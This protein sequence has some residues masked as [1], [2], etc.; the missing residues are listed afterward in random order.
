MIDIFLAKI[1]QSFTNF[2]TKGHKRTL[3]AKKNIATSFA[4]KGISIAI[5]LALVPLTI[6]YINPTQYGIWLT[7]SSIVAW[8]S[9]FDIGF[10]H[11]LRNRFAE[12]KAIGNFEKARIYISTTYA[13]LALIFTAVWLLFFVVN[14]F[15]DWSKILNA[16]PEM[17][18]ELSTLALIVFSFFCLQIVLKTINTVIIAD[19][20]PAKAAFFDMLGQLISL[21]IIYLLTKYTNGSLIY[22]GIYLGFAPIFVLIIS[23]FWFYSNQYKYIAPALSFVKFAYTKDILGLG[24]KFFFI[25]F[26]AIIIFQTSNIIII[27]VLGP[28]SVTIYNIA[29]KYFFAVGMFFMIVLSPFWSAFTEAYTLRDFNW[30]KSTIKK[31]EKLW[32][33]LV[34]SILIML[35]FSNFI[36]DVWI[37]DTVKIPF[38]VSNMMALNVI[39]YTRY[40]IYMVLINGIGK[41]KLQLFVVL[42]MCTCFFPI[43]IYFTKR[44]GLPGLILTNIFINIIFALFSQIQITKL[45]TNRASGIWNK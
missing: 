18:T 23:S 11:G 39:F 43:A 20:K 2:F 30:M 3:E 5:N 9:F 17:A 14:F 6:H 40:N 13:V 44:I 42:L 1:R 24:I 10:G 12:A 16:P 22:L 25:Q 28:G 7:L 21:I 31:L 36:F 27:Q 8:F 33:V 35:L 37:G 45:M 19:Q 29:N 32:F 34:P 4:I 15:V 26:S 38:I 41:I